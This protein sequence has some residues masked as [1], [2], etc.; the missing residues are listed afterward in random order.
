[1]VG[2]MG[3]HDRYS[4]AKVL[5]GIGV[6]MLIN[7]N[8][9]IEKA[10]EKIHIA[11]IDDCHY[12]GTDDMQLTGEGIDGGSFKVMIGH[13]PERL[14]EAQADGYDLY[15]AGHTHAGQVCLPGG[16]QIVKGASLPRKYLKGK[17]HYGKMKGYTSY[18]A[19]TSGTPVRF[20]CEPEVAIV[21]L[22]RK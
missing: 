17:W 6:E 5:D 15:L 19:G 22:R 9:S 7:E 13:S 21:T 20:F 18:G 4:V 16:T 3:N 10:D 12:Y 14:A 2:V 11:G 1:V 8:T